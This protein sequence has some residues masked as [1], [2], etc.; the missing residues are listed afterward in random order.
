M[1]L[2]IKSELT[3]FYFISL[4]FL[5]IFFYSPDKFCSTYYS[6]F[7]CLYHSFLYSKYSHVGNYSKCIVLIIFSLFLWFILFNHRL[8]T[9]TRRQVRAPTRGRTLQEE[10]GSTSSS[11]ARVDSNL[12]VV[13]K[14]DNHNQV[15]D[16]YILKN[17]VWLMYVRMSPYNSYCC[18]CL[19]YLG[20]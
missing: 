20:T 5:I 7:Y 2:F 14:Q 8:K 15:I 18:S 17:F 13:S 3:V 12:K 6:F 16:L 4:Y 10:M 9:T 11:G 19:Y 1:V